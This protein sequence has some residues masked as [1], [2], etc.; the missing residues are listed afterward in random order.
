MLLAGRDLT[1]PNIDVVEVEVE[2]LTGRNGNCLVNNKVLKSAGGSL[3]VNGKIISC[4][5]CNNL[6]LNCGVGSQ[7]DR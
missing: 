7:A 4:F 1:T 2:K 6:L 5:G 3:K